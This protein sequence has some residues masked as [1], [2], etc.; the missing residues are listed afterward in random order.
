MHKQQGNIRNHF[1]DSH[2]YPPTREQ[3]VENTN[4]IL[5]EENHSKLLIS[6]ALLILQKKPLLNIQSEN[7]NNI[8]KLFHGYQVP[9]PEIPPQKIKLKTIPPQNM[10]NTTHQNLKTGINMH[11]I[12]KADPPNLGSDKI[13]DGTHTHQKLQ[14][15]PPLVHC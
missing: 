8:L 4:I 2:G 7:F 9:K 14:S 11:Q 3:L 5:K 13:I 15:V 6:E 12:S 1:L 10:D